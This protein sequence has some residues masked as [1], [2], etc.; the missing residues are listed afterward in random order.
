MSLIE[1]REEFSV[2]IDEIDGQHRKWIGIINDLHDSLTQ[3]KGDDV[4]SRLVREMEEYTDFHFSEE[5]KL[6]ERAGYPDLSKH[7]LTHYSFRQQVLRLKGEILNG[8]MVLR[9]QV[10]SIVKNWLEEHILREDKAYGEFIR[11]RG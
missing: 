4:L 1:W 11:K 7:R 2:G 6:L 3:S 10:M 8:E 9:T 5:E